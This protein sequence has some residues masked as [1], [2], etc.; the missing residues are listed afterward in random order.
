M[1]GR[2][3]A[4]PVGGRGVPGLRSPSAPFLL[5]AGRSLELCLVLLGLAIPASEGCPTDCV[6][7]PSPMTVSCQS[8]RFLTIPEGI[9]ADSE[10]IFLQNN[11]ISLLLRG[12]FSPSTVTLWVYSNNL[13]FVDPLAFRGFSRLEELDLGDNRHL[14]ELAAET[15][16]GLAHLHALHLYKCGL[17]ALP[18]GLF[19]GLHSL[20]YLYLQDNQL[21]YLQEDLFVDLANLSHLFLHGN[22]LRSLQPASFRGL[23]GLDR[24]LLH[25]NRLQSV[26]RL[27]FHDLRQLTL[28]FLFNNSLSELPGEALAPLAALEYLRLNGNPWSCGCQ[29]R[30]LW[31]WLR[32]FRGSSSS[33]LC[34]GPQPLHGRDLKA[35]PADTFR[36]CSASESLHQTH[37]PRLPPRDHPPLSPT[38][39]GH[40]I[41][42]GQ[43]PGPRKSLKNCTKSRNRSSGPA[44]LGPWKSAEEGQDLKHKP[45]LGLLPKPKGKCHRPPV[46]PP[47]GVQQAAGGGRSSGGR[48]VLTLPAA[49]LLWTLAWVAIFR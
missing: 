18:D 6:C 3:P 40:G 39:G 23:V 27:A 8:H 49:I 2:G 4:G 10:R 34:E 30:S 44:S 35:L 21:D 25:Q 14:R 48:A 47:S 31:D 42:S 32:R 46:L 9:P 1:E 22:R 26:H 45:N 13:T 11:Q 36:G 16:Q 19:R 17:S 29:A 41:Q 33:V 24:L 7:Y 15:F 43:R 12:H 5:L 20:Q 28:L 38:E 37:G